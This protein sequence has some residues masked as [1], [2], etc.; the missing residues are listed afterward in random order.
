MG[1]T[2]GN[3]GIGFLAWAVCHTEEGY[4]DV[5]EGNS[6]DGMGEGF[7]VFTKIFA[8]AMGAV[9]V[10]SNFWLGNPFPIRNYFREWFECKFFGVNQSRIGLDNLKAMDETIKG[11]RNTCFFRNSIGNPEDSSQGSIDLDD[12]FAIT[13]SHLFPAPQITQPLNSQP[14]EL[15]T[16]PQLEGSLDI[17]HP[18]SLLSSKTSHFQKTLLSPTFIIPGA[19]IIFLTSIFSFISNNIKTLT[20]PLHSDL[21]ITLTIILSALTKCLPK[22]FGATLLEK[23]GIQRLIN[24]QIYMN[25]AAILLFL[26]FRDSKPLL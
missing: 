1:Y 20:Y 13:S 18:S 23:Y 9:W 19:Y 24:S 15:P 22:T 11:Y 3:L 8:G 26:Y 21:S 16:K 6:A 12:E 4:R 25:I 2:V 7:G 14:T 10:V 17:G 5:F